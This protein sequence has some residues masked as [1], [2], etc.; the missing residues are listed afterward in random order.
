[1]LHEGIIQ[2]KEIQGVPVTIDL[3]PRSNKTSRSGKRMIA[4][5][6][7]VHNTGNRSRGANADMHTR[8]VDSTTGY[9]SW[10]FTVD[11][12]GIYQ[13]LPVN[14]VAWHAGDGGSGKGNRTSIS[15]EICEHEGID[16]EKAK[17]NAAKLIKFLLTNVDRILNIYPHQHWSGKYCPHR[18][19]DE[20]WEE[21]KYYVVNYGEVEEVEQTVSGWAKEAQEFVVENNISDGT[22]PKDTVTREEAW[23]MIQRL[24]KLMGGK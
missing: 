6:I 19:L 7:T 17:E 18:I 22:R 11:D 9:V 21:F 8:Y 4:K 16:W 20:G 5:A 13:E 14:E 3:I 12:K 24:Y 1:M 10:H 23:V 15:I 2:A